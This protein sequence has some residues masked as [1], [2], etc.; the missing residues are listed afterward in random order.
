MKLQKLFLFILFLNLNLF[1]NIFDSHPEYFKSA[2]K[3]VDSLYNT[4]TNSPAIKNILRN[5]KKQSPEERKNILEKITTHA[6]EALKQV[7]IEAF[8]PELDAH[9]KSKLELKSKINIFHTIAFLK[10]SPS[11][12]YI[13]TVEQDMSASTIKVFEADNNINNNNR[14]CRED[15]HIG[16]VVLFEFL[17]EQNILISTTNGLYT[18]NIGLDKIKKRGWHS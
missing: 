16:E 10:F 3:P 18:V 6:Q 1:S 2:H 13:A 12:R 8:G 5:L 14:L 4:V 9:F 17:D 11:G 15:F 7:A